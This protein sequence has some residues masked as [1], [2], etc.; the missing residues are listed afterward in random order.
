MAN[1]FNNYINPPHIEGP[2]NLQVIKI[3]T[4]PELHVMTGVVGH[5][6][7]TMIKAFAEA[8]SIIAKFMEDH[9]ISW[10]A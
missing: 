3:L 9:N 4:F 7:N 2:S 6:I 10:C 8:E 1:N 5:L